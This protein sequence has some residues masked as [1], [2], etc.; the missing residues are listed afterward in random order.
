MLL[1]PLYNGDAINITATDAIFDFQGNEFPT[2]AGYLE[3]FCNGSFTNCQFVPDAS[4][5]YYDYS[6]DIAGYG[7][8]DGTTGTGDGNYNGAYMTAENHTVSLTSCYATTG[9]DIDGSY[10]GFDGTLI[11]PASVS[12]SKGLFKNFGITAGTNYA[13]APSMFYVSP[14]WPISI[15][16]ATFDDIHGQGIIINEGTQPD[17][18]LEPPNQLYSILIDQ[19][20]F[21]TFASGTGYSGFSGYSSAVL[22]AYAPDAD[23]DDALRQD[24]AVTNN[25]FDY[26]GSE[27]HGAINAAIHFMNATGDIGYNNI[28]TTVS[29]NS[30]Y[31]RGIWN[32]SNNALSPSQTWTFICSNTISGLYP[33]GGC[34]GCCNGS[35]NAGLYTDYYTGYAKLNNITSCVLGQLSS[36]EDN[37]HIDFS[38]YTNMDLAAYAGYWNSETDLAGVHSSPSW[39]AYDDP[40]LNTFTTIYSSIDQQILL[41]NTAIVYLGLQPG[42]PGWTVYG[43]NTIIGTY[44]EFDISGTGSTA[45]GDIS[46]NYWGGGNYRLLDASASG[47]YLSSAPTNPGFECSSGL[48]S[49]KKSANALSFLKANVP[50]HVDTIVNPCGTSFAE[51]YALESQHIEPEGYDTLQAFLEDCPLYPNSYQAFNMI[52]GAASQTSGGPDGWPGFLTWLK[53]VLYYNPDTN[54]YCNDVGDMISAEQNNEADVESICKYILESGKCPNLA[55]LF[56]GAYP[57]AANGRHTAWLDS[58]DQH[59]NYLLWIYSHHDSVVE[60]NPGGYF[61]KLDSINADTLAHPFD[62]T[63]PTLWQDSLEVLMGPQFAGVQASTPTAITSQAL[64]SAQLLENPMNNEIDVSYDMGR[65]ALVTME[66]RDVLGRSVPI[67]NAKYQLEQPGDHTASIPAPN[68]PQGIY[69]LRITTDVGDAITL[70]FVKE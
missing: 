28:T 63:V 68:L 56:A 8:W 1:Y 3:T 14:W 17:V 4:S 6:L 10:D 29:Y 18:S 69:Y 31:E 43:E 62:S 39:S 61:L 9:I 54:W 60:S 70:K 58:I 40:A 44:P 55:G 20:D 32:E 65:T 19:N 49:K 41:S 11:A 21:K 38:T 16:D 42:T 33:D 22:V 27:E 13:S 35:P 37:G 26:N 7:T 5:I 46:N 52:G 25:S 30:Q 64:L 24:I 57:A 34:C 48:T 15:T 66:L 36:V 51:G 59:Y 67:A 12:I 53:K 45:L 47:G 50:L 2:W 23:L